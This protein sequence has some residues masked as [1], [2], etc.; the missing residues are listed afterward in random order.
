MK[1]LATFSSNSTWTLFCNKN[2]Q[3]EWMEQGSGG[4]VLY[5]CFN[6]I[7]KIR[8]T[9]QGALRHWCNFKFHFIKFE[10]DLLLAIR[11]LP[12]K[13]ESHTSKQL[14]LKPYSKCD[15]WTCSFYFLLFILL[16]N[17]TKITKIEFLKSEFLWPMSLF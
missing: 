9:L 1:T 6:F 8:I 11:P 2:I 13:A 7:H 4:R 17:I 14:S 16:F 10:P 3:T 15:C 5:N 12:Y